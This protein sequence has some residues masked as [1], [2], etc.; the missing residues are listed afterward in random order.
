MIYKAIGNLINTSSMRYFT[1][2]WMIL[3]RIGGILKEIF[4]ARLLG[5]TDFAASYYYFIILVSSLTSILNAVA[6]ILIVREMNDN[7][8]RAGIVRILFLIILIL[9]IA[10]FTFYIYKG[11]YFFGLCGVVSV[12]LGGIW[13]MVYSKFIYHDEIGSISASINM[14]TI[15]TLS[16][17]A[18]AIHANS[19]MLL[20]LGFSTQNLPAIVILGRKYIPEIL[21]DLLCKDSDRASALKS[22]WPILG[23]SAMDNIQ[24]ISE[25]SIIVAG[26]GN[27][28]G[29]FSVAFRLYSTFNSI[30]VNPFMELYYVGITKNGWSIQK[31][32]MIILL[33]TIPVFFA[34][35]M[36]Y[37]FYDFT[38]SIFSTILGTK[39]SY[40]DISLVVVVTLMYL[41]MS[42][43][44]IIS[45]IISK[46]QHSRDNSRILFL[47]NTIYGALVL[48]GC[49]L[50]LKY[51]ILTDYIK[52]LSFLQALYALIL[53]KTSLIAKSAG[54]GFILQTFTIVS[55]QCLLI[56]SME[57]K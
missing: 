28:F 57:I 18:F 39:Y 33:S 56:L 25:R 23:L 8:R 10:I 26:I 6:T 5:P 52:F 1:Y 53:I 11:N 19:T 51:G 45:I 41:S 55:L 32:K 37:F 14:I 12:F 22:G 38:H 9:S 31:A 3:S 35:M 54:M 34:Q 50:I 43:S 29:P 20:V 30:F 15:W 47:T 44:Y 17:T 46:L 27:L 24:I 21:K 42:P 13:V 7:A 4:A 16:I 48:T 40:F 2:T 36:F 49:F